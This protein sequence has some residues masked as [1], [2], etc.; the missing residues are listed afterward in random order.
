MV[1]CERTARDALLC[2]PLGPHL[3]PHAVACSTRTCIRS[4]GR[5]RRQSLVHC[6]ISHRVRRSPASASRVVGLF[7]SDISPFHHSALLCDGA[8]RLRTPLGC[9]RPT[10][11]HFAQVGGGAAP[12]KGSAPPHEPRRGSS[13]SFRASKAAHQDRRTAQGGSC[14]VPIGPR[15]TQAGRL[16]RR[17]TSHHLSRGR[18][19]E[20][21]PS[22][23]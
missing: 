22:P 18:H 11:K 20:Q 23:R 9:G 1:M 5:R 21:M 13:T 2:A 12:C 6:H 15:D 8:G 19:D 3:R 14:A 4:G 16:G 10:V 17:R 7:A